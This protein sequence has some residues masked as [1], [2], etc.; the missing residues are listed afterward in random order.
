MPE[1]DYVYETADAFQTYNR[2]IILKSR[3]MML[4]WE[5]AA[6]V[7][8]LSLYYP[9][10]QALVVSK[11]G[12][13]SKEIGERVEYIK[14]NL[15]FADQIT[16]KKNAQYTEYKFPGI[17]DNKIICLPADEDVT[18][19]FSPSCIVFDEGAF[20]PH[21]GQI[22]SAIG[23]LLEG[24]VKFI[25]LSTPNGEDVIFYPMWHEGSDANK[26]A[27]HYRRRRRVIPFMRPG[28]RHRPRN[29]SIATIPRSR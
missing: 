11:G 25:C 26:I 27:L 14:A 2:N 1:W 9:P 7:L 17:Q 12:R 13:Y 8:W 29:V 23:P 19:T 6:F 20:F 15:S 4:S 21:A 24:K 18:R 22:M 5:V 3:Q 16:M 28:A 10:S